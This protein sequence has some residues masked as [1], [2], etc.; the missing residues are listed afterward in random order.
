MLRAK[1]LATAEIA[2]N[3]RLSATTVSEHLRALR[4]AGLVE[5]RDRGRHRFYRL[6]PDRLRE[7]D[8][9]ISEYRSVLSRSGR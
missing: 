6:A 3:F 1:D 5:D 9:W 8:R 2:Q 7:L 4:S